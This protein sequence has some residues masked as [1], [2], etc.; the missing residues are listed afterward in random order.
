MENNELY[1]KLVCA[2]THD[3]NVCG[4]CLKCR[5]DNKAEIRVNLISDLADYIKEREKT[6]D[7]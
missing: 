1:N 6:N 5:G 2:L 3:I 4:T 7:H